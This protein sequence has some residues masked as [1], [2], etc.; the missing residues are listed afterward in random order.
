MRIAI[1]HSF[2]SSS[3]PSGENHVVAE[4][5]A[6]LREAGH[7]VLLLGQ[8]TDNEAER[9]LYP[10]RAA[11][12]VATG[13]G[14]D[15]TRSLKEFAPDVVHIHNLFP[16]IG[17]H[18]VQTWKG[19]VVV[20]LHNFRFVCSN[21]LL[22]RAGA[23]CFE[24]PEHGALRA[25]RHACYRN[26]RMATIPVALSRRADQHRVLSRADAVVTTSEASDEAIRR[27]FSPSLRT[28]LIPN[29][30]AEVSTQ[31]LPSTER[32]GWVAMGRLSPEK[33]FLELL[34]IWPTG[35]PLD[36]IGDGELAEQ[37]RSLTGPTINWLASM[38]ISE[39]R[40]RLPHYQGL[41]FPSRWIE[42]APQVVVEAMR[43]GLPVVAYD[44]NGVSSFV[45]STGTGLSYGASRPLE[46]AL[47]SVMGSCDAFSQRAY[48]YFLEHWRQKT[49]LTLMT[50]LY[51]ELAR[52]RN[53][54]RT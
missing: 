25:I 53:S 40:E 44:A 38:P 3:R 14:P 13:R 32:R 43:A 48:S 7:N 22:Y 49:W 16:N 11:A 17:T 39:L 6:A 12:W 1:V 20:S 47:E 24:C 5:V 45:E 52:T 35:V 50:D 10:L 18:W 34:R 41:V 27:F 26:S 33:G 51:R 54:M 37:V 23:P 2:Y 8:H 28:R 19:P 46:V 31:P 21:A 30:G 4:Q 9:S 15:P 36:V 29:F 42:A